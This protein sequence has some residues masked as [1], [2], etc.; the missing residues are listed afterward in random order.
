MQIA[1]NT[2]QTT[3]GLLALFQI[4]FLFLKLRSHIGAFIRHFPRAAILSAG[5]SCNCGL[6]SCVSIIYVFIVCVEGMRAEVRGQ[7]VEVSSFLPPCG[8]WGLNLSHETFCSRSRFTSLAVLPARWFSQLQSWLGNSGWILRQVLQP[9]PG[10]WNS[11]PW[12][13]MSAAK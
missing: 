12:M 7:L 2:S 4:R 5:E 3:S 6:D 8:F 10:I 1:S 9:R 13:G 11:H